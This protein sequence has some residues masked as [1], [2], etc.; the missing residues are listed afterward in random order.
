MAHLG[1]NGL[2]LKWLKKFQWAKISQST[3]FGFTVLKRSLKII[4]LTVTISTSTIGA[5]KL[6]F[7]WLNSII[8]LNYNKH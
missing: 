3:F 2:T 7:K 5:K 6:W 8:T 4:M 1:S